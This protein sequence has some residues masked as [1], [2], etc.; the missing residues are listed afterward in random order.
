MRSDFQTPL[1][2][3][4]FLPHSPVPSIDSIVSV[5]AGGALV[6]VVDTLR[7]DLAWPGRVA[8]RPARGGRLFVGTVPMMASPLL[9]RARPTLA[10]SSPCVFALLILLILIN[11]LLAAVFISRMDYHPPAPSAAAVHRLGLAADSPDDS[12]LPL[13]RLMESPCPPAAAPLVQDALRTDVLDT[14]T[15]VRQLAA[16]LG[17]ADVDATSSRASP[18]PSTVAS[19]PAPLPWLIVGIPTVARPNAASSWYLNATLQSIHAQLPTDPSDPFFQQVH[20]LVMSHQNAEQGPHAQFDALKIHFASRPE[21][22]FVSN[23]NDLVDET[24]TLRDTGTP[25]LPGWKV[26]KQTR[27]IAATLRAAIGRSRYYL[28][29]EDDF[30]LCPHFFKQL[31]AMVDKAFRYHAEWF[32]LKFSFGMNGYLIHNANGDSQHLY[33]YLLRK[34]RLRPPDHLMVEWSAGE[35]ES[36]EYKRG[37]P[38]CVYRY[39]LLYHLGLVSSLRPEQNPEYP[40]CFHELNSQIA[41]EVESFRARECAHDDLW[42]CPSVA[43]IAAG[44]DERSRSQ[45]YPPPFN[46]PDSVIDEAQKK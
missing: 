25:D 23:P 7:S 36:V 13:V 34:Q 45:W 37:R 1:G 12:S 41:F 33:E 43:Q 11:F 18:S 26:R 44:R 27:D 16:R 4:C 8:S 5:G 38:H 22:Q 39:N 20:V 2:G 15:Q 24:P 19:A 17:A 10:L 32:S 9:A 46:I 29:M 42:P 35:K 6:V 31:H 14:L 28:V 40:P 21:F 3:L 30:T